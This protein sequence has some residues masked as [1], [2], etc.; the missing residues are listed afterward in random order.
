MQ[1]GRNVETGDK[2]TVYKDEKRFRMYKDKKGLHKEL[3]EL[4]IISR[5]SHDDCYK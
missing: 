3:N 5:T 4:E 1:N 2:L